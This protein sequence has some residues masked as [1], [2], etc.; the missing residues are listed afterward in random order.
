MNCNVDVCRRSYSKMNSYGAFLFEAN[1]IYHFDIKAEE[2]KYDPQKHIF[3]K[4][5]ELH[6]TIELLAENANLNRLTL[7]IF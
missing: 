2:A 3:M 1:F 7:K 5:D 6:V 4:Y